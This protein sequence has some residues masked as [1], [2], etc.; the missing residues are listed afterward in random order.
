MAANGPRPPASNPSESSTRGHLSASSRGQTASVAPMVEREIEV[1]RSQ[2]RRRTV[3]AY[4]DGDKVVVLIQAS[5]TKA[6]EAEWVETMV[7]RLDKQHQRRR[8]SD[9]T[10]DRR[11]GK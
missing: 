8:P 5:M 10:A 2:R 4:R 1:R 9:R 7:A 11:V 3:S 6:Q